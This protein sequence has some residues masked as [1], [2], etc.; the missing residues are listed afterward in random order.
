MNNDES[1]PEPAAQ[2]GEQKLAFVI[3]VANWPEA[4]CVMYA[5]NE[6]SA[7]D[8]ACSSAKDVGYKVDRSEFSAKRSPE[9]DRFAAELKT[10]WGYDF[11]YI[12]GRVFSR[13]DD[14]ERQLQSARAQIEAITKERD[15]AH[16]S[17]IAAKLERD[18]AVH[19][20]TSTL[21]R[22]IAERDA[23]QHKLT[24]IQHIADMYADVDDGRPNDMMKII[25]IMEGQP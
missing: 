3:E 19:E 15:A 23:A 14:T 4:R 5:E 12:E 20:L 24:E 7:C 11:A 9:Y 21:A 13:L 25:A 6:T 22:V 16:T 18:A 2:A 8:R 10:N 17:L 1:A